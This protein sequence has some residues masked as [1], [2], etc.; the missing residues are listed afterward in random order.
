MNAN[1]L[2]PKMIE[3]LATLRKVGAMEMGASCLHSGS[4]NALIRRGLIKCESINGGARFAFTG[5]YTRITAA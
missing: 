5:G 3:T 2:T 4:V 1:D